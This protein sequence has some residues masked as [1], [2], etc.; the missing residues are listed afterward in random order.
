MGDNPHGELYGI[1]RSMTAPA[2]KKV[3]TDQ[4]IPA[5]DASHDQLVERAEYVFGDR[6]VAL[7]WLYDPNGALDGQLPIECISSPAGMAQVEKVLTQI[8]YNVLP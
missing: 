1:V 8:E 4:I 3:T 6:L 7:Q 2:P 5:I